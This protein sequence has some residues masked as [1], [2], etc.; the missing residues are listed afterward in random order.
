MN[1]KSVVLAIAILDVAGT[2][3]ASGDVS[4]VNVSTQLAEAND[5]E[6][7]AFRST[8]WLNGGRYVLRDELHRK[9]YE[10]DNQ[11]LAARFEG[12]EVRVTG[13]LD[14]PSNSVHVQTID[15]DPVQSS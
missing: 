3:Y 13:T 7:K 9:W 15:E 1:N 2:A 8:V 12:K 10:L 4:K 6:M 5:L 14:A 11:R